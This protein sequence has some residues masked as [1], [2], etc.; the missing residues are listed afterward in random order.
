MRH[1]SGV[2]KFAIRRTEE[3]KGGCMSQPV[4]CGC[5]GEA[6]LQIIKANI[7]EHWYRIL[8]PSCY[9]QTK[10][11]YSEAEAIEVWNRAMGVTDTNVG[12]KY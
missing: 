4:R 5:G 1:F 3:K 6:I 8:C 10:A 11:Y 2:R 9:V 7:Y 12:D